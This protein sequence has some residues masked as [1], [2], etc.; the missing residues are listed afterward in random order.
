MLV[1]GVKLARRIFRS[2]A[3]GGL[4]GEEIEPEP[5]ARTDAELER[6][7]RAQAETLYH[8]V[9]TCRMGVAGLAV[10]D[11]QLRVRGIAGLRVVDASVMP[12]MIH[13]HPMAPTYMTAEQAVERMRGA[14]IRSVNH[15][16]DS[17]RG[18]W[19]SLRHGA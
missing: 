8:P 16:P 19:Y 3:L 1:E 18:R 5:G 2:A 13:G 9:G 15:V 7:I 4:A 12:T 17:Q 14:G 10:V 11:P 6:A